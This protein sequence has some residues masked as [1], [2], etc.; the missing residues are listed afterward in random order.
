MGGVSRFQ[1]YDEGRTWRVSRTA[2]AGSSAYSCLAVL[3]D[4]TIGLL[5]ERDGYSRVT[6]ARFD[7]A[8]LSNGADRL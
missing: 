1:A 4:R 7:L 5:Y 3:P 2:H 8:W 6:F